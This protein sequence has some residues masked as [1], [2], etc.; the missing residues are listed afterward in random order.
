MTPSSDDISVLLASLGGWLDRVIRL[1]LLGFPGAI[2]QQ[3]QHGYAEAGKDCEQTDHAR[4]TFGL[5]V[6]HTSP[7]QHAGT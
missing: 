4:V 5:G 2:W 3:E 1:L 6:A 7:N